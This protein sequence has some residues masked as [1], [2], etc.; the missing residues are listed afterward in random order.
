MAYRAYR[1]VEVKYTQNE[2]AD[3]SFKNVSFLR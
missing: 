2:E 1:A 3:L